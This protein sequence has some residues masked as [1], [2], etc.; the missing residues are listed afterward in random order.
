MSGTSLRALVNTG[1][2]ELGI[3]L[4]VGI[5]VLKAFECLHSGGYVH[6][7]IKP[8]SIRFDSNTQQVTLTNLALTAKITTLSHPENVRGKLC[9]SPHYLAP[10]QT[11]YMNRPVDHR[12]DYYALGSTLYECM[13]GAPPFSGDLQE[14]IYAHLAR[15]PVPLDHALPDCPR[16]VVETIKKLLCKEPNNR[17]QSLQGLRGDLEYCYA[18]VTSRASDLSRPLGR[19]FVAGSEDVSTVLRIPNALFGRKQLL[20][21]LL[22]YFT[23]DATGVKHLFLSGPVG[24]GKSTL[25]GEM[26]PQVARSHALFGQGN[27][28][29]GQA[30]IPYSVLLSA[31]DTALRHAGKLARDEPARMANALTF[32]PV[33][34]G[35]LP[36]LEELLGPLAPAPVLPIK[37]AGERFFAALREVL[38]YLVSSCSRCVLIFEDV[39]WAD[40]AT[41]NFLASLTR[42]PAYRGLCCLYTFT[43]A[44]GDEPL[45]AGAR[46]AVK[47]LH[48]AE[49]WHCPVA[50]LTREDTG[51][52]VAST[53]GALP[54]AR[55]LTNFLVAHCEGLP[56]RLRLTIQALVDSGAVLFDH[57]KSSWVVDSERMANVELPASM[58]ASYRQ[59]CLALGTKTLGI[60]EAAACQ[61]NVFSVEVLCAQTNTPFKQTF[62]HLR[63]AEEAGLIFRERS[64]RGV[65][66]AM[67][68]ATSETACRF[69][70][71]RVREVLYH[72]LDVAKRE[73]LHLN[74]GRYLRAHP[75]ALGDAQRQALVVEHM[76]RGYLRIES[77]KERLWLVRAHLGSAKLARSERAFQTAATLCARAREMLP[78]QLWGEHL[79]LRIELGEQQHSSQFLSGKT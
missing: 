70:H 50:P 78:A 54:D 73:V 3:C 25:V 31:L 16:A 38:R 53:F 15:T 11:G 37:E 57:T 79:E 26:M 13:T 72:S 36:V 66:G 63:E 34:S 35:S 62:R 55:T 58:L 29:P 71:T 40:P 46:A 49:S 33:L 43:F 5:G 42:N 7:D 77:M 17:Y 76:A 1:P 60:L 32:A 41:L 23:T 52:L 28:E 22:E 74:L 9:G 8:A 19:P 6:R 68:A 61:G 10:E 14:T 56:G 51:R 69:T 2:L 48:S 4:A 65:T 18:L 12:A 75:R 20:A 67:L 44:E 59:R 47:F 21:R 27:C 24:I 45:S 30:N 39:Q 64:G